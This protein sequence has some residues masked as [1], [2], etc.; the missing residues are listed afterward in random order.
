MT[1][2]HIIITRFAVRAFHHIL[3]GILGFQLPDATSEAWRNMPP[4][5]RG[6]VHCITQTMRPVNFKIFNSH[7]HIIQLYICTHIT[8]VFFRK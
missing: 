1:N 2:W 6:A 4:T 3:Y 8:T 7:L 5:A